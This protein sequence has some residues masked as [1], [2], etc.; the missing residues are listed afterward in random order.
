MRLTARPYAGRDNEADSGGVHGGHG[1][2]PICG[3]AI[4]MNDR[5]YAWVA[6][7]LLWVVACLNYLDR[8]M[9]FSVFPLLRA[10]MQLDDLQ[11]GLLSTV[12]LWV[13]GF[14]S[15]FG[16]YLADRVG[17]KRVLV[18]S[19]AIWTTVTLATGYVRDF[20]QL[21]AARALMGISEAC[22]LPAALAL[23]AELHGRGSRSLATGIHQ[24]GL[25]AGMAFGGAA[26]GWMG[27]H[28][29]WRSP[30]IVLGL[31]GLGYAAVLGLGLRNDAQPPRDRPSGQPAALPFGA[32]LTEVLRCPGFFP[33]LSA[34]AA[35]AVANWI[36]Y[37]WLPLFLYERFHMTLTDAAFTA[38][39]YLQIA[40]LAGILSGGWIAD[41]WGKASARGRALTQGLGAIIAA[42]FLFVVGFTES[43]PVAIAA[44]I[45][46]GVGKGFYDCST[47]PVLAQV[48]RPEIRA[49]GYGVFNLAGC[50]IGGA[51][52]A[53]AGALKPVIGLSGAIQASAIVLISA[54]GALWM[55]SRALEA[56]RAAAAGAAAAEGI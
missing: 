32:S 49:T 14:A 38:T 16:G 43:V 9:I 41:R 20:Q 51:M 12:F 37:T 17:R 30:F 34:F 10:E 53:V 21:L 50:V 35:F 31:I 45:A 6:V 26:G 48:A 47:M 13:Y 2:I 56:Q 39:F 44:L 7:G 55:V 42:P 15:P 36:V 40:S 1:E 24:T 5:R 33:M 3:G 11:L 19:L 54:A 22:Y 52:A 28:H 4:L 8:Q 25:Y 29:G 18:L 46:F 23:I 27:E